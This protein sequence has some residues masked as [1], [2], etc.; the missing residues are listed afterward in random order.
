MIDAGTVDGNAVDG[1]AV[2]APA[3]DPAP[4]SFR[5]G[6]GVAVR[7]LV[8]TTLSALLMFGTASAMTVALPA[9]SRDFTVPAPTADWFL[10]A[11]L[12][13]NTAFIL[14][15]GRLSDSFG[16]RSLYLSGLAVFT[17]ASLGCIWAPTEGVLIILRA[18]QGLACA[19]AVSNSTAVLSDV[20]PAR[21]LPLA[22]S[23]N[24]TGGAAAT[25]LG[26]VV[27]GLLV[28][29]VGWRA[30]FVAA[31][32]LGL[33]ALATG[34]G[35]LRFLH[36]PQ[37]DPGTARERYDFGGAALSIVALCA[38]LIGVN[39]VSE[40]GIDDPR[41]WVCFAVAVG[42]ALAFVAVE[43]RVAT[44]LLDLALLK[45]GRGRVYLSSFFTSFTF[46]SVAV[47]VV[48]YRQI[49]E[50]AGASSA[51]LVIVPMGAAILVGALGGGALGARVP[52][53]LLMACGAGV[54]TLGAIGLA[55]ALHLQLLDLP[56]APFLAA[57]G[58]GEGVYMAAVTRSIMVGVPANRRAIA[59]GFRS[60][61]HNGA[62]ALSTA[63]VLLIITASTGQSY[64]VAAGESAR[65]GFV[66]ATVILCGCGTVGFATAFR[67]RRPSGAQRSR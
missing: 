43:A 18:V 10:L 55:A 63:V 50:G 21:T 3:D 31:V 47:L 42:G 59:N 30:I 48:L 41:V 66:V 13:A 11:F 49:V 37:A 16:R 61:L 32:P 9:I 53:W 2:P 52:A 44:P 7:V 5:A 29:G 36:R 1:S 8:T 58:L 60:V 34:W 24:V 17:L 15:F 65:G 40:W 64:A 23:I 45:H 67:R 46:G 51:G 14:V 57:C 20:F 33:A 54:L 56:L 35:S 6:R 22:L 62:L 4:A 26:P 19:C 27:G 12:L 25:L 39:R 28:E 38:L